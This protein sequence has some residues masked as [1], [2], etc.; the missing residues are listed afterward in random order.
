MIKR[1]VAYFADLLRTLKAIEKHLARLAECVEDNR[2][3]YGD[4]VSI[5]TRHW[6]TH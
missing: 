1:I 3:T 4:R 2:N 6:N 5:S